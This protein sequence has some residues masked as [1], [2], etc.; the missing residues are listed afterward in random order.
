MFSKIV[1]ATD[2]SE[3]ADAALPLLKEFAAQNSASVVVCHSIV[4][5][6]GPGSHG[7]P[8][9][10]AGDEDIEAK[11][12]RQED[13]LNSEGIAASL[14]IVHGDMLRGG[15]ARDIV[16]IADEENADLIIAA[17]RGH[18]ALGGLLVGSVTQRLLH[19]ANCP[20]VV[21]PVRKAG[22]VAN[23]SAEREQA[24]A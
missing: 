4:A 19:L 23:E 9:D 7:A 17:T 12:S 11:L 24:I 10:L 14:R 16:R 18:T 5:V 8:A 21:V 15:A 2:G 1:W 20:V 22:E 3:A 13:E 6:T